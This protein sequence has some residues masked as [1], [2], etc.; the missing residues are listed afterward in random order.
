MH[1]VFTQPDRRC[2]QKDES[3]R[4]GLGQGG[5]LLDADDVV[6]EAEEGVDFLLVLVMAGDDAGVILEEEGAARAVEGVREGGQ[7][8]TAEIIE[9]LGIGFADLAQEEAL[10]PGDALTIV[11]AQL[12]EEPVGFA[13]AARAAVTDGFGS[14]RLIAQTGGGAGGELARLEEDAGADE[15]LHLVGGAAGLPAVPGELIRI[16]HRLS[17]KLGENTRADLATCAHKPG[18][19]P[20]IRPPGTFSPIGGEGWD[21]G[22]V[23]GEEARKFM[24]WRVDCRAP[25]LTR[26][27]WPDRKCE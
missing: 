20:L 14:V 22:A 7:D 2:Q 9:I 25:A 26:Q 27:T 17:H 19:I 24:G 3:H 15:I 13:A 12:G 18:R 1:N 21:E 6:F 8:A 16:K 4:L 23:C 5:G 10:E 11:R